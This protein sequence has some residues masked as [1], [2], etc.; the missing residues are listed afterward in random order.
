MLEFISSP[1]FT[2]F[3]FPVLSTV[4][5]IGVKHFSRNDQYARFRKEDLAIGV[6]LI[7]T[8]TLLSVVLSTNS[9]YELIEQNKEVDTLIAE[10][11][12][13]TEEFRSLVQKQQ[14]ISQDL[15]LSGWYITTLFIALGSVSMV[16]RKWGWKN[17]DDIDSLAGIALP[18]TIGILALVSVMLRAT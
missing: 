1:L 16:M 9:A 14:E 11:R 12:T 18:V 10:K 8:A 17:A 3:L 5:G 6:E 2:Y 15:A 13:D 4:L 7:L